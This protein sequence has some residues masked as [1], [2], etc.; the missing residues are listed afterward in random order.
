MRVGHVRYLPPGRVRG[1]SEYRRHIWLPVMTA[2]RRVLSHGRENAK[3]CRQVG[4]V[5]AKKA[6][7]TLRMYVRLPKA[8]HAPV[9]A[10]AHAQTNYTPPPDGELSSR[11]VFRHGY[12][13]GATIGFGRWI[14]RSHHLRYRVD[15]I[16]EIVIPM[17]VIVMGMAM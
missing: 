4:G 2:M 12:G 15:K 13:V 11:Y 7:A 16:P 6:S 10:H 17:S 3:N 1:W 14:S 5:Q 8:F 9:G